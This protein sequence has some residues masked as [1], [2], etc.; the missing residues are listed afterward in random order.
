MRN[1]RNNIITIVTGLIVICIITVY[2]EKTRKQINDYAKIL[3][4]Q[5]VEKI[6]SNIEK[7]FYDFLRNIRM[8]SSVLSQIVSEDEIDTCGPLLVELQ[9]TTPFTLLSFSDVNGNV[10]YTDGYKSTCTDSVFFK[11]GMNGRT[12]IL[13]NKNLDT[14]DDVLLDF[15]TPVSYGDRIAGVL[16]GV[17]STKNDIVPLL[18]YSFFNKE[19][20]GILIDENGTIITSNFD[21]EN[22]ATIEDLIL[23][24]NINQQG[25]ESF[26]EHIESKDGSIFDYKSKNGTSLVCVNSIDIANWNLIQVVPFSS[27]KALEKQS[28]S[29][30]ILS[31]SLIILLFVL[32]VLYIILWSRKKRKEMALENEKL[33]K[34]NIQDKEKYYKIIQG[35]SNEY[36][37]IFYVD[38]KNNISSCFRATDKILYNYS[39]RQNGV[40]PFYETMTYYIDCTVKAEDRKKVI[41]FIEYKNLKKVLAEKPVQSVNYR[42]GEEHDERYLQLTFARVDNEEDL[43]YVVVG[44]SDV[45]E[46]IKESLKKKI[47]LE[48]ALVQAEIASEESR[49]I[50]E[51]RDK[52]FRLIHETLNSGMW[53]MDFDS[54]G[55]MFS[56]NWSNELRNMIGYEDENDFPNVLESWSDKIH[57][58]DKE[59]TLKDY[60]DTINDYTGQKTHSADYRMQVSSGEWR[61]FHS[62]GRLSRRE[63]GTPESYVGLFVD[64]TDKK[65]HEEREFELE[66]ASTK[67]AL[68]G[69]W[70]RF[71]FENAKKIIRNKSTLENISV[72]ALDVNN[73]KNANDNIGHSAGDELLKGAANCIEDYFGK[74]GN[75]YRTGGD[76]FVVIIEKDVENTSKMIEEFKTVLKKWRGKKVESLSISVGIVQAKEYPFVTFSRLL[77][78]ADEKMYEEKRVYH[79]LNDKA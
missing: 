27:L 31:E 32:Y 46:E 58:E 33:V 8:T 47:L 79:S 48:N 26:Y 61:W 23:S 56:V 21:T 68:T 20:K 53:R 71:A 17:L 63:D 73:L 22:A 14:K 2:T 59:A 64:I 34:I 77:Q 41:D 18:N 66:K 3:V 38:L 36:N 42:L 11:K 45:D 5:N 76:E 4:E 7:N 12:G 67:D 1:R 19:F 54:E 6:S 39:I 9:K 16:T 43:Q 13:V 24:G 28:F 37:L 10:I 29:D 49:I 44:F 51:D 74:Y 55:K 65:Y 15:Y 70:N 60:Y 30:E 25:K 35:L 72:V 52:A 75:C 69:L 57:P 78:L 50:A 62:A 40:V